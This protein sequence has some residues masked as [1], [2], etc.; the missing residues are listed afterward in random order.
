MATPPRSGPLLPEPLNQRLGLL[1]TDLDEF[2]GK[3]PVLP[4]GQGCCRTPGEVSAQRL[5]NASRSSV[6]SARQARGI[7]ETPAN[8]D[9]R[10]EDDFVGHHLPAFLAIVL[11]CLPSGWYVELL[12]NVFLVCTKPLPGLRG[13]A[14]VIDFFV[15]IMS[16]LLSSPALWGMKLHLEGQAGSRG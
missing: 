4:V 3:I 16:L 1:S 11:D 2:A 15:G 8:P 12:A 9:D 14:Q 5:V 6:S 7:F 10:V 13:C